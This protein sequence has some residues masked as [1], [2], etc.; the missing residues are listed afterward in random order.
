MAITLFLLGI[1]AVVRNPRMKWILI[2]I[3]MSIFTV[4][5]ILTATIPFVW[6]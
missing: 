3:G 4:T 5:A 1:A 2:A 6:I